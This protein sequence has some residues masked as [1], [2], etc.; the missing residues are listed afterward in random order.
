MDQARN[1]LRRGRDFFTTTLSP[2]V[3]NATPPVSRQCVWAQQFYSPIDDSAALFIY[4]IDM[5]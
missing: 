2:I 1:R 3:I 5:K 4:H